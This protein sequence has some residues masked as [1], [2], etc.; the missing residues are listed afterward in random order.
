MPAAEPEASSR[1]HHGDLPRALKAAAVELIT[2]KGAAGFSLREV[3][4]RA[5]VSHAAPTHHF[6]DSAGL[7][8][9]LAEEGFR[10]L[11]AAL[12]ESAEGAPSASERMVRIARAY[13]SVA[14]QYPAHCAVMF[15]ADLIRRDDPGCREWGDKAYQELASG[16]EALRD[17]EGS[18][19]DVEEAA[20]LC[21]STMQGLVVLYPGMVERAIKHAAAAGAEGYVPE[22]I[23]DRAERYA[24][25]LL[26]GL[27]RSPGA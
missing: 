4:R 7:L 10:H 1:Y 19:L 26:V 9:A 3:A 27:S 22:S 13:V 15:R 8:T 5:G 25:L 16:L 11:H 18:D 17:E 2:E 23:E 6:G 24:R 14:H 12:V 21:W 20:G